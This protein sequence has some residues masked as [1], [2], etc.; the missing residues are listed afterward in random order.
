M[1]KFFL[2]C[3]CSKCIFLL[4]I[5]CTE[6]FDQS[7]LTRSVGSYVL[8]GSKVLAL[9]EKGANL[10]KE[11]ILCVCV[12]YMMLSSKLAGTTPVMETTC[13]VTSLQVPT[14]SDPTP[15]HLSSSVKPPGPKPFRCKHEHE[16]YQC[17][18]W[19]PIFDTAW[20]NIKNACFKMWGKKSN[21]DSFQTNS[22]ILLF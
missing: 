18:Y 15:P 11:G 17:V 22:N 6:G 10:H 1:A 14:S 7:A 20:C 2:F 8:W 21:S 12:R 16:L 13:T 9:K 4:F 3:I 5:K 19:K